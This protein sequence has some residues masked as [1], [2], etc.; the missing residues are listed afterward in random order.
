[1]SL[2]RKQIILNE[3]AFWKQNKLLPEHY[4]DF[5]TA[6]YAQGENAV[7]EE[8]EKSSKAV[9][10]KEKGKI[11]M[12][13]LIL[14]IITSIL[15]GSL[16]FMTSLA[17]IPIIL[18]GVVIVSFLYIAFKLAKNK[19]VITPILMVCSAL[20]LLG[21]S[22]K[23]WDVYFVDYPYVLIGLII[24]NCLIWLFSGLLLKLV[25]FSISGIIGIVFI[26]FYIFKSYY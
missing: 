21:A 9:L 13:Y 20:L 23:I 4:C 26:L 24:G 10:S 19:S 8:K 14:G 12:A 16:I 11:R 1:M 3:I 18:A 2:Q 15:I 7:V 5:L 6:L 17:F 22:F 25:Y